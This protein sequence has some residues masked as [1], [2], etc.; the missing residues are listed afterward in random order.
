MYKEVINFMYANVE[1]LSQF[2]G[3]CLILSYIFII[4]PDSPVH[5][6][7]PQTYLLG[8]YKMSFQASMTSCTFLNLSSDS[9]QLF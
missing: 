3:Q 1:V 6:F 5:L 4:V 9:C 2:S 7:L 8:K